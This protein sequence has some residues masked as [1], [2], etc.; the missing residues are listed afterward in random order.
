MFIYHF[1]LINVH[2]YFLI[3]YKMLA[4]LNADILSYV[5]NEW[6]VEQRP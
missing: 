5:F 4:R 1:V 6:T 3:I 2:Y